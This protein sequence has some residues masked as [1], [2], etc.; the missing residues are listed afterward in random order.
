MSEISIEQSFDRIVSPPLPACKRRPWT[1][2]F[3][4]QVDTLL[5]LPIILFF[6]M[7]GALYGQNAIGAL[8]SLAGIISPI[9]LEAWCLSQFGT[10]PG[11]W[12]FG[13]RVLRRGGRLSFA[14]AMR[15]SFGV[16]ARGMAM[17]IPFLSSIAQWKAHRQLLH[18]G[19]TPW[20]EESQILVHHSPPCRKRLSLLAGGLVCAALLL[21]RFFTA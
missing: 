3:A 9:T 15:R 1:R 16:W 10:T 19:N 13:I 21:I 11:K 7:T 12:F 4:R 18:K 2:Y 20:D 17:G 6:M 8:A 5:L 14:H